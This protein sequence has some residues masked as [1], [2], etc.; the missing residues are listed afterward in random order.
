M[1]RKAE[2]DGEQ[3]EDTSGQH[4]NPPYKPLPSKK[5]MVLMTATSKINEAL[6]CSSRTKKNSWRHLTI[7]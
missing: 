3:I 1:L 2:K 4:A 6:K 5:T 7:P